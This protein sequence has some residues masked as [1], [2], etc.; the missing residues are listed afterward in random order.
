MGDFAALA[1]ALAESDGEIAAFQERL[2]KCSA[3]VKH[4]RFSRL[5]RRILRLARKGGGKTNATEIIAA[6]WGWQPHAEHYCAH[7]RYWRPCRKPFCGMDAALLASARASVSRAVRRLEVAN[8]VV[9][10]CCG[11]L[12]L[13]AA[14]HMVAA[15]K[16]QAA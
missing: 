4:N 8:L 3:A 2:R 6:F 12:W 1:E 13:T 10:R 5:Q 7:R 16:V 15:G 11:V 14:G 9:R